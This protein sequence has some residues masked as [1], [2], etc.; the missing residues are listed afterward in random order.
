MSESFCF[1]IFQKRFGEYFSMAGRLICS[2]ARFCLQ[3]CLYSLYA[4]CAGMLELPYFYLHDVHFNLAVLH[5]SLYHGAKCF[6]HLLGFLLS[7]RMVLVMTPAETASAIR[8]S[9]TCSARRSLLLAKVDYMSSNAV[10]KRV[11]D[12]CSLHLRALVL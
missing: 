12:V 9:S 6:S 4:C 11:V 7:V 10:M 2:L 5:S 1:N 8:N 3:H